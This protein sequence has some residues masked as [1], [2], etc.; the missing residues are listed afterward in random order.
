MLENCLF[1]GKKVLEQVLITFVRKMAY[2]KYL[3]L[4]VILAFFCP[5]IV[6]NLRAVQLS[7]ALSPYS[8]E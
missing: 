7:H 3:N 4:L 8:L 1:V 6:Y 2:G 5:I